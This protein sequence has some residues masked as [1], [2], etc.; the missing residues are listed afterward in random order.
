MPGFYVLTYKMKMYTHVKITHGGSE[1]QEKERGTLLF[2]SVL[3]YWLLN[4][5]KGYAS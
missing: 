4:I 3:S 2:I 1:I 5:I